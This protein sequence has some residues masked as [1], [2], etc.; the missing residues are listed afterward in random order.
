VVRNTIIFFTV[1]LLLWNESLISTD[2]AGSFAFFWS[3]VSTAAPEPTNQ[4]LS[5]E[6]YT[7]LYAWR[8]KLR[9]KAS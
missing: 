1:L 4:T 3:R 7:V 6:C 9:Q 5:L 8:K 2:G